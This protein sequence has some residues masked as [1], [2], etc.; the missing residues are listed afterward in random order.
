MCVCFAD[1]D[2]LRKDGF[3]SSQYYSQGPTFSGSGQSRI[4]QMED[5]DDI[6]DIDDKVRHHGTCKHHQLG[7]F[8]VVTAV[9]VLS[10]GVRITIMVLWCFIY[11]KFDIIHDVIYLV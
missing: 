10:G 2:K 5:E 4:S 6:D 8:W 7:T 3:R 11:K 1:C 9:Y